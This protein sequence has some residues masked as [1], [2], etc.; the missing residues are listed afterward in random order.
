MK[1]QSEPGLL[2]KLLALLVGA[3]LLVLGFMFSVVL[4]A[5]VLVIGMLAFA[6]FWWKTRALR[7]AMREQRYAESVAGE[8]IEGESF[9][10]DETTVGRGMALPG[11]MD[12][13]DGDPDRHTH[14]RRK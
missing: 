13:L 12:R 8:V 10:V 14:G 11:D 3:A 4:L 2:G 9:V 5:I 6:Y 1:P 7:K